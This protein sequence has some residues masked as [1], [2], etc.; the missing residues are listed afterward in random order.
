M[1]LADPTEASPAGPEPTRKEKK[2]AL[3]ATPPLL[4]LRALVETGAPVEEG[5]AAHLLYA[6]CGEEPAKKRRRRKPGASPFDGWQLERR[7]AC[8]LGGAGASAGR[9]TS[10]P[11]L[12]LPDPGRGR[13]CVPIVDSIPPERLS[14]GLCRFEV[15]LLVPGGT[16]TKRFLEFRVI[17]PGEPGAITVGAL[18]ARP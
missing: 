10:L 15:R 9:M 4:P 8:G 1:V 3:T 17:P 7:L 5:R 6:V 18:A 12:A 2:R 11:L 14:P 13:R 16:Q